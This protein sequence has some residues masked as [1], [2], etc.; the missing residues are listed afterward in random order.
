MTE[1]RLRKIAF[2][3]EDPLQN[4]RA[5]QTLLYNF[6]ESCSEM[7]QD[8]ADIFALIGRNLDRERQEMDKLWTELF[9]LVVKPDEKPPLKV[10]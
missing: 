8:Q 3:M 7:N 5:V 1:D 2:E 4:L 9:A 10:A 6:V